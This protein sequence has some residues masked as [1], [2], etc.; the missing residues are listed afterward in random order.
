MSTESTNET[1]QDQIGEP[2]AEI[3]TAEDAPE[4]V[5]VTVE[6]SLSAALNRQAIIP[7]LQQ[8]VSSLIPPNL[9]VQHRIDLEEIDRWKGSA[10]VQ[11][12]KRFNAE[13]VLHQTRMTQA[14]ERLK[15]AN[16]ELSAYVQDIRERYQE[17]LPPGYEFSQID[18][19]AGVIVCT[20][21]Q[22]TQDG[23]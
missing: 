6:N 13:V 4:E 10:K 17:L 1:T 22:G 21:A 19:E 14:Q 16:A 12:Q 23:K 18:D 3:D 9:P 7:Q 8:A 15:T 20:L 11:T 2:V 5:Q